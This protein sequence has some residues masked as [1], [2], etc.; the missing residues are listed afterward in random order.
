MRSASASIGFL[1]LE[2]SR[3]AAHRL[4]PTPSGYRTR[5]GGVALAQRVEQ[6]LRR[7][8]VKILIEV[9]INLQDRRVDAGTQTF[10]LHQGEEPV[11]RR[12]ANTDIELFLTSTQHFVRAA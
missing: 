12:A 3:A 7:W 9:I 4:G 11:G 6:R 1:S 8:P 2:Q 10:D 5:R